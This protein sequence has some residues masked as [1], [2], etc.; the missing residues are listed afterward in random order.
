MYQPRGMDLWFTEK[1]FDFQN[2]G[3][4]IRVKSQLLH[5]ETKFQV[6]SVFDT[7]HYGKMMTLDG[8]IQLTEGDENFYHEMIA[9]V[10]LFVHPDPKRV[11]VVG[12]GDGG[13][14]REALKHPSV[15]RLD[16]AEIDE[17]VIKAAREFFPACAVAFDDSRLH[18]Q[19]TD[20]IKWVAES[21]NG[22]YDVILIDSSDPIGPAVGLFTE[23]FYQHC[24]RVLSE[25]GVVVAQSGSPWYQPRECQVI[26]E[27]MSSVF[28]PEQVA[29]YTSFTPTYPSGQMA[30]TLASKGARPLD[31]DAHRKPTD[32]F[33]QSLI[34]YN[35][36][37]HR[38]AFALPTYLKAGAAPEPQADLD[39]LSS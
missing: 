20:A 8:I 37:V 28:G 3:L 26:S 1:E 5:E 32:D 10:P 38:G 23:N 30:Y 33:T 7:Y 16:L 27:R 17:G 14:A 35:A 24:Q 19:V 36:D 39:A 2:V 34:C 29:I 15:E 22:A 11:L 18:L 13:T 25:H 6:L 21:A 12:G 4:T 9:H 31:F